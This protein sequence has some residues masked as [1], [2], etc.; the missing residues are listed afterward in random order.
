M[1]WWAAITVVAIASQPALLMSPDISAARPSVLSPRAFG[2][3]LHSRHPADCILPIL[4]RKLA[5]N[6]FPATAIPNR[7]LRF[8]VS[9]GF[10][11]VQILPQHEPSCILFQHEV[12]YPCTV[13]R[14][15]DV[16]LF[17]LL[18]DTSLFETSEENNFSESLAPNSFQLM[19][20]L[21][22]S[23]TRFFFAASSVQF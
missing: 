12:H 3:I 9:W 19:D 4:V 16:S 10:L 21:K 15:V 14:L 1:E 6:V 20:Q 13:E 17:F 8:Q 11:V 5:V 18:L 22:P 7:L 23:E 2:A